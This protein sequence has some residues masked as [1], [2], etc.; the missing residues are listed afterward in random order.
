MLFSYTL[1]EFQN[2]A[3]WDSCIG[4]MPTCETSLIVPVFTKSS[5]QSSLGHTK[6]TKILDFISQFSVMS[7]W[8][9]KSFT[10]IIFSKINTSLKE[11]FKFQTPMSSKQRKLSFSW[12]LELAVFLILSV[13]KACV[14]EHHDR[15]PQLLQ[16]TFETSKN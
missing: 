2:K 7:S 13:L 14:K 16:P 9:F 15:E 10:T 3:H 6:N 11:S 8:L 5:S 4:R 1:F 12:K